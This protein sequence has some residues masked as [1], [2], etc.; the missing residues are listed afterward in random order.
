MVGTAVGIGVFSSL[1]LEGLK[2]LFRKWVVKDMEYDFPEWV[3]IIGIPALNILLIPVL[4]FFGFE[5]Y[6]MPTDW[7]GWVRQVVLAVIS[8]LA[9]LGTYN[10]S[11][12]PLKVYRR[13]RLASG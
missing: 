13:E 7:L 2:W 11:L 6:V 3:Y 10:V 9:T 4:A 8:A 5:E 12:K 1:V